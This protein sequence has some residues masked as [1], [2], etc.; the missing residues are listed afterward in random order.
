MIPNFPHE[1]TFLTED[2]RTRLVDKLVI[3]RG[4]EKQDLEGV[5]YFSMIFDYKKW[6]MFVRPKQQ[7]GVDSR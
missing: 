3:D 2:E 6:L 7:Q 5:S 1:A 4:N